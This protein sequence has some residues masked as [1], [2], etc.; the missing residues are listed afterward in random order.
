M[1]SE[2]EVMGFLNRFLTH[3][4]SFLIKSYLSI[5]NITKSYISD[6]QAAYFFLVRLYAIIDPAP[7]SAAPSHLSSTPST[8]VLQ[9]DSIP[10]P[11]SFSSS[12]RFPLVLLVLLVLGSVVL[13]L[14]L[15]FHWSPQ[16]LQNVPPAHSMPATVQTPIAQ[17]PSRF[18]ATQ[19]RSVNFDHIPDPDAEPIVITVDL[20]ERPEETT[21]VQVEREP[22]TL[23]QNEMEESG[24]VMREEEN[25]F[26]IEEVDPETM[27]RN[28]DDTIAIRVDSEGPSFFTTVLCIVVALGCSWMD[29]LL[30]AAAILC[31][32]WN[33]PSP[34]VLDDAFVTPTK[35]RKAS[36]SKQPI[37]VDTIPRYQDSIQFSR[38]KNPRIFSA[39][40]TDVL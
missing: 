31:W 6:K 11:S 34:V 40:H 7:S 9:N 13:T 29:S 20:P 23:M 2:Q 22:K 26:V 36:A 19:R 4:R 32:R 25:A 5:E 33:Q 39:I 14:M 15:T 38:E 18:P 8:L 35:E 3:S 10:A 28:E 16:I 12:S 24:V 27:K 17:S 21:V 37:Y 1:L 30:I